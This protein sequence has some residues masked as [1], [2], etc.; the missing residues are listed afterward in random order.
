MRDNESYEDTL[1]HTATHCG[2]LQHTAIHCN[3]L[4]HTATHCNTLQHTAAH[5]STLQHTAAHCNTLQ[6]TATHSL[7]RTHVLCDPNSLILLVQQQFFVCSD[8]RQLLCQV[9]LQR[10]QQP[11]VLL[12]CTQYTFL[13]THVHTFPCIS[14]LS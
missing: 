1:R 13:P 5:C 10:L 4:Q 9:S 2:A 6:R 8:V 14:F 11:P 7:T 12:K 3:T